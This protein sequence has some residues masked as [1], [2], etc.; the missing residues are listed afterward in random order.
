MA[1]ANGR[2]KSR[3][4]V[5]PKSHPKKSIGRR[6]YERP[7]CARELTGRSGLLLKLLVV[8]RVFL[9]RNF[10]RQANASRAHLF[11]NRLPVLQG[12]HSRRKDSR[13]FTWKMLDEQRGHL[14]RGVRH[15]RQRQS[16]LSNLVERW[17]DRVATNLDR[18]ILLD[19]AYD[20]SRGEP[21]VLQNTVA[22]QSRDLSRSRCFGKARGDK[23]PRSRE[24][25]LPVPA[26]QAV[27]LVAADF[28]IHFFQGK[29]IRGR[30]DFILRRQHDGHFAD[31][32]WKAKFFRLAETLSIAEAAVAHDARPR[33]GLVEGNLR[34]PL[35]DR[36]IAFGAFVKA[37]VNARA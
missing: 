21:C 23:S 11:E 12:H 35:R 16:A 26:P 34:G 28:H 22:D 36:V 15:G 14:C 6:R 9:P 24:F 1:R 32:R 4:W 8:L 19:A 30:A 17:K 13:R 25:P 10:H 2:C 7:R 37:N 33:Y 18:A 29:E 20:D 27:D 5:F 31:R 3:F